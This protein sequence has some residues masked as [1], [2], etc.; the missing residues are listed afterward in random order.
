MSPSGLRYQTFDLGQCT[1]GDIWRVEIS[2]W[3]NV[4]MVDSSNLTSFKAGRNFNHYG[5][6]G[7]MKRSPHDFVVPR[8]GRW[9]VVAHSAGLSNSAR[10]SVR[11]LQQAQAM[12]PATPHQ[13]NLRSIANNA[14]IYGGAEEAPP[15]APAAKDYDVFV[16]HA[17]EDKGGVVRPLAEALRSEGLKVWY[18]EFELRIGRSLRRSIDAGL[19]NS[20]F[21]VV[22]LSEAFFGK[23]W[24]NYELDGLVTREIASGGEQMILPLW[25]KVS[26][27]EV[28]AY[29][30]SLAD[31]LALSTGD[32]T[33]AEI[34]EE[35]ATVV[36][37]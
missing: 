30:P 15:V 18:D 1:R 26:K 34:A 8:A 28:T 2:A 6:G 25:H 14:A 22:V 4:F 11:Q 12:A 3:A 27:D 21:G 13:V 37:S 33:V 20:R 16:C 29:S 31:K 35:I 23:D 32:K 24:A 9:Y 19:A 7:L 17:S 36:R 5:G 10:V